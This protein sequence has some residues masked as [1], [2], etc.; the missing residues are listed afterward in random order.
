VGN[1]RQWV[2]FSNY[3]DTLIEIYQTTLEQSKDNVEILRAQGSISVL[4]KV[5]RLREEVSNL[6]G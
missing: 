1:N 2:H 3:L 6:D 5:K 4:R